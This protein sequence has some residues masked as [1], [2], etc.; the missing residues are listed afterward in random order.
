[1]SKVFLQAK[2]LP[3]HRVIHKKAVTGH[4]II[5]LKKKKKIDKANGYIRL[6]ICFSG[7]GLFHQ[8]YKSLR[9]ER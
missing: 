5:Q 3:G 6:W 4:K 9:S 7:Y 1:M 8:V 2:D